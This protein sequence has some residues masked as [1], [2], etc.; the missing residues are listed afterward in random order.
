MEPTD[1]AR[2]APFIVHRQP[3]HGILPV[4]G[5]AFPALLVPSKPFTFV[6]ILAY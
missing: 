6:L 1:L 2:G 3:L 4:L 5:V